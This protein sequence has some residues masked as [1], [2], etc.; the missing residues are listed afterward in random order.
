M[1]YCQGC[2]DKGARTDKLEEAL[3]CLADA[4]TEGWDICPLCDVDQLN[5]EE[6]HRHGCA[7]PFAR[8]VLG[9]QNP[10]EFASISYWQKLCRIG[11]TY[12]EAYAHAWPGK[13]RTVSA[14][15]K[16]LRAALAR[17]EPEHAESEHDQEHI[18]GGVK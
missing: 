6:S 17:K 11:L 14:D 5:G 15:I 3:R 1:S 8:R 12:A 7:V 16:I 9:G 4:C 2:A 13:S 18:A 10:P